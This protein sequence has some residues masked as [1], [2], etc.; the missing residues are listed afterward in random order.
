MTQPKVTVIIPNYNGLKF[1]KPCME[2]LVKQ[3]YPDYEILIMDNASTDGSIEY[4]REKFPRVNLVCLDKNYGFT[5]AVNKGIELTES[6]YFI[7]LNNDTEVEPDFVGELVKAIEKS[8]KIFSC[9]SKMINFYDREVMDDAGDL[10]AI[11][12]WAFQK[13]TGQSI[14]KYNKDKSIFSACGGASIYRKKVIDEIGALDPAHFA[15]LEDVDLGYRAKIY[16]Y[17]NMYCSKS[18]VYHVG[19]GTSGSKY[20]SFKVKLTARNSIYLNYKNMPIIQLVLNFLFLLLGFAVKALYFKKIGFGRDYLEGLKEGLS[21]LGNCRKVKF[22]FKNLF[23]YVRI[24][25]ELIINT[26]IYVID[27]LSRRFKCLKR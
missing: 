19:S 8:D 15:Y 10:Y 17:R 21:G 13:G 26:F 24:E 6:P 2:S 14:Y 11:V 16:G 7:L 4:I 5:G 25:I 20:N 3:N 18:I 23:N 27:V 9:N 12:G 22:R 1:L